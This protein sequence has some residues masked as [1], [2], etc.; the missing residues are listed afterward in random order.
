V[1]SSSAQTPQS[2][3]ARLVLDDSLPAALVVVRGDDPRAPGA[4]FSRLRHGKAVVLISD[5]E[6]AHLLEPAAGSRIV[7][8]IFKLRHRDQVRVQITAI[9][10][11]AAPGPHPAPA[12][13]RRDVVDRRHAPVLC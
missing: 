5:D 6:R 1:D 11:P 13:P 3:F 9:D 2:T 12:P 4:V 10:D 8:A 7:E